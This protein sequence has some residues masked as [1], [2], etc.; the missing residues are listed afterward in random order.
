[1]ADHL[2]RADDS[3]ATIAD[4]LKVQARVIYA[5]ILRDMRTRFGRSHFGYLIQIAWPLF[6]LFLLI[7]IPHLLARVPPIGTDL[8]IYLVTAFLP[9]VLLFYPARLMCLAIIVARPLLL[10]PIVK[11][12]DILIARALLEGLTSYVVTLIAIACLALMGKDVM[13]DDLIEAVFAILAIIFV[14]I[15]YGSLNA[16]ITTMFPPWNIVAVLTMVLMYATAMPWVLP[17]FLTPEIQYWL[18]WN[19]L[20]Q[21]ADWL[22]TAYF[23]GY[24]SGLLDRTYL[25]GTGV[26][27][28][29]SAFLIER[30]I[31][32]RLL[33]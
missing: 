32:G 28:F 6:H 11:S 16:V 19:P 2:F 27:T 33:E 24:Q 22:K 12:S 15:G 10:F 4:A 30:A 21:C 29:F 5:L 9:Y 1:M 18:S 14:G 26:L 13:P 20:F 23:A 8:T 7:A 3:R 17:T 31:R 25:I